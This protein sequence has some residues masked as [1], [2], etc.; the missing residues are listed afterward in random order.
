M[1]AA[2]VERM[3]D[4]KIAGSSNHD[5][6]LKSYAEASHKA[7]AAED[8]VTI[9]TL[10]KQS[11]NP[12]VSKMSHL[13]EVIEDWGNPEDVTFESLRELF[14]GG[15]DGD[16]AAAL[17]AGL[18]PLGRMPEGAVFQLILEPKDGHRFTILKH[19]IFKDSLR[20]PSAAVCC[21]GK[22]FQLPT[23]QNTYGLRKAFQ[24]LLEQIAG[25]RYFFASAPARAQ[26]PMSTGRSGDKWNPSPTELEEGVA[27][28]NEYAPLGNAKNQQYLWIMKEIRRVDS[29]IFGWPKSEV[30][31]AAGN[32]ARGKNQADSEHFFPLTIMDLQPVFR[33]VLPLIGDKLLK[34]RVIVAGRAGVGKTQFAK[35]MALAL[36]RFWAASRGTS[37]PPGWRRGTLMDVFRETPG[38]VQEGILLDDPAPGIAQL[39]VETLKSFL[40]E[41]EQTLCN[42]RYQPTKF[43]KNQFRIVMTNDW[44]KD[45]EPQRGFDAT[46]K[47][48]FD[49]LAPALAGASGAHRDAITKRGII[50]I[51]GHWGLYLRLPSERDDAPVHSFHSPGLGDDW[52]CADNEHFLNK[53]L[54]GEEEEHP[55]FE[56]DLENETLFMRGI[57][58]KPR[59]AVSQ[60]NR[61]FEG[62]RIRWRDEC[63]SNEDY[64]SR[65]VRARVASSSQPALSSGGP[66]PVGPTNCEALESTD[67]DAEAALISALEES[68]EREAEAALSSALEGPDVAAGFEG[69]DSD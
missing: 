18:R 38:E 56:A 65:S 7:S 20:A 64:S 2:E 19:F 69:L 15:L 62:A 32:K 61:E 42:S 30:K 51:A 55:R 17:P 43:A 66:A 63:A 26:A 39:E 29:P 22:P 25:W 47:D 40:D 10:P 37:S 49:M 44:N 11:F 48:F 8:I 58:T 34:H 5:Y 3:M 68:M 1:S 12:R 14:S 45:K 50:I 21:V 54:L 60:A 36:G 35:T 46:V 67:C 6:I 4:D 24:F 23:R 27:H 9:N 59:N 53:Y 28:I 57:L 33:E 52:L 13:L 31:E 16:R 41:G